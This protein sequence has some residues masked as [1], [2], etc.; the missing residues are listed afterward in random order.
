[1]SDR[2]LLTVEARVASGVTFEL[3]AHQ[4]EARQLHS[5]N[6]PIAG[7]AMRLASSC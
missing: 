1:M 4:R 6:E 5:N 2:T 7:R 3:P